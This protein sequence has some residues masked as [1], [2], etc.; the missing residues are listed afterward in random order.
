MGGQSPRYQDRKGEAE[1]RIGS[2]QTRK[3]VDAV[4]GET[5]LPRRVRKSGVTWAVERYGA[6]DSTSKRPQDW[7]KGSTSVPSFNGRMAMGIRGPKKF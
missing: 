5:A 4:F 3:T 1:S 2:R 7:F 6:A